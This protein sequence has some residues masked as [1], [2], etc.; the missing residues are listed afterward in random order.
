MYDLTGDGIPELLI[1]Y[2]YDGT[3]LFAYSNGGLES[4][5]YTY[6]LYEVADGQLELISTL[7]SESDIIDW[8]EETYEYTYTLNG[9]TITEREFNNQLN[10]YMD[11]AVELLTTCPWYNED[12]NNSDWE[13]LMLELPNASHTY[14]E[15]EDILNAVG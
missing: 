7:K 2:D 1:S 4:F 5:T 12:L 6:D 9:D 14:S 8:D 13:N 3:V 10:T 11:S 15:A